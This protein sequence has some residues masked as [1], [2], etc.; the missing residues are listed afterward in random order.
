MEVREGFSKMCL[1]GVKPGED[2]DMEVQ[3]ERRAC[4]I[5]YS[6]VVFITLLYTH[7]SQY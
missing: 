2:G 6:H 1:F 7:K 5:L 4:F 3:A